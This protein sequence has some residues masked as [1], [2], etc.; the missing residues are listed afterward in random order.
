MKKVYLKDYRPPEFVT[1]DVF[2]DIKIVGEKAL[3]H[4]RF[5]VQRLEQQAKFLKLDG[6]NLELHKVTVNGKVLEANEIKKDAEKVWV[7]APLEEHFELEIEQSMC[8]A[9]NTELLG[10][11]KSGKILCTQNEPEGMRRTIY[12]VDRPDNMVRITTR[13][14]GPRQGYPF[15]L[16]NGNLKECGE[17]G[18]EHWFLWEDPHPKPFYLFALV[19]GDLVHVQDYYTTSQGRKVALDFYVDHGRENYI[20]HAL[21]SLKK[22]MKW[23]EEVYGL[24]YDLDSYKIVATDYFLFG[25]MENKGLN[26]FSQNALVGRKDISTDHELEQIDA[27]VAHEYF[28]N[29][30]GNRVT[31]RDWFQLTL[32]EG[33]T[34]LR[35]HAYME[36]HYGRDFQRIEQV[37]LLKSR[38]FVEDEGPLS[39]PIQ[40]LEYTAI[41]NF[42]TFTIYEKGAEIIRM[43]QKIVGREKYYKIMTQYFSRYDGQAITTQDLFEL[44]KAEAPCSLDD[45]HY[46]YH[47][48]GTPHL[49]LQDCYDAEKKEYR[50]TVTQETPNAPDNHPFMMPLEIALWDDQGEKVREET[51]IFSGREKSF[52]FENIK[53]SPLLSFN[54]GLSAPVRVK[55]EATEQELWSLFN[56]DDDG[57][58]RYEALQSIYLEVFKKALGSTQDVESAPFAEH[59]KKLF[60]CKQ[61]PANLKVLLTQLPT[62]R[63]IALLE[64]TMDYQNVDRV[65]TSFLKSL[66]ADLFDFLWDLYHQEGGESEASRSLRNYYL[67][68]LFF[69]QKKSGQELCVT[70][71]RSAKNMNDRLHAL[72]LL[73]HR[74]EDE[75]TQEALE[76]FKKEFQEDS[77]VIKKWLQLQAQAQHSGVFSRIEEITRED[78]FNPQMPGHIYGLYFSFYMNNLLYFHH[79]SGKGYELVAQ[80]IAELDGVVTSTASRLVGAFHDYPLLGAQQKELMKKTLLSLD[81][82]VKSDMTR[83]QLEKIFKRG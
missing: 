5:Q 30:S 48:Q 66:G 27:I 60:S 8:P 32:K 1:P 50:L 64:E 78:F 4:S 71:L 41:D 10:L 42:Y 56:G 44:F 36:D 18:D 81:T 19:C 28:H 45:F 38:Q 54:R 62:P 55:K 67:S 52:C 58:V 31:L 39:H 21:E 69:S 57:V 76:D 26:I 14:Q 29:W 73:I 43:L 23:D 2:L 25:A 12:C 53:S 9:Q 17:E 80:K 65:R 35:E 46:W 51:L 6:I 37:K 59:F 11:Y 34:V 33:L 61:T 72:G 77:L 74:Y 15:L 22:A 16:C 20:A 49:S 70:H 13:I 7:P 68:L 47:Q 24:P 75:I 79:E 63:E 83:E 3:I 40:P 82:Q